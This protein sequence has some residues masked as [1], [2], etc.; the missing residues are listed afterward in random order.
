MFEH[1]GA[2][3]RRLQPEVVPDRRPEGVELLNA[4]GNFWIDQLVGVD[5]RVFPD[6]DW[7][8][9]DAS[10]DAVQQEYEAKGHKVFRIAIGGS[11]PLGAYSFYQA[12]LETTKQAGPFDFLITPCSSGSTHSGL[13]YAFH[14]T[15]THV[16]GISADPM[17]ELAD[18]VHE[19][20]GALDDLTG[21]SRR[22]PRAGIDL[23]LDYVGPGYGVTS[24]EGN[25]AMLTMLRREGILLDPIYSGKAFAGLLNMVERSEVRGRVLFWHTGGAPT[26]FAMPTHA[27]NT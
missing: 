27:F 22:I 10:A 15:P 24:P 2:R 20:C 1:R 23:R 9:L 6:A 21:E 4:N 14:N 25:A 13:A 17:P 7:D 19:L 18:D 5:V 16:I 12:G 11:S 8:V 3:C 26:L